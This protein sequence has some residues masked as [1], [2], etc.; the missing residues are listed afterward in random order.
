[1]PGDRKRSDQGPRQSGLRD[2][3]L[4]GSVVL[5]DDPTQH[6]ATADVA[7]RPASRGH[8]AGRCGHLESKTAVRPM[9]VVMPDVVAKDGFKVVATEN[10]RPVEAL[11][12]YGPYPALRDRV[13]PRRSHRCLD[14][15]YAFG[16]EHVVEAGGELGVAVSDQ[17]PERPSVL[18]E[19]SREVAGNLGDKEPGRMIGDPHDV[20]CAALELDYEQHIELAET[21]RVHD[22]EVGSQDALGLGGDE[23]FPGRSTARSWSETVAAK[24]P[25]DRACRDAD[26]EP[27]KLA[28]NANTTPAAVLTAES[29]DELDELIAERGTSRAPRRARQ[30]FHLRLESSRCQRSRVSGVT[31]KHR[32]RHLGRSRLSTARIARSVVR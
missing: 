16:G 4:R 6:V 20:D 21:D 13:R 5:V 11:F 12:T 15:L 10:E 23:L 26:P 29:D 24:D 8:F 3:G 2:A 1:M 18:G 22:E 31:R 17:E 9:L 32:Q 28:L 14:H 30:R 7:E 19:I 25:A 27:A